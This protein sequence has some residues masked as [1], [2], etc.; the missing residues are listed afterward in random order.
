MCSKNIKIILSKI[1]GTFLK[2]H[3]VWQKFQIFPSYSITFLNLL[4]FYCNFYNVR[5]LYN[6]CYRC[7]IPSFPGILFTDSRGTGRPRHARS[8]ALR[9]RHRFVL[10]HLAVPC[11]TVWVNDN[12]VCFVL[13]QYFFWHFKYIVL[14]SIMAFMENECVI[15]YELIKF[16]SN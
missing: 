15:T 11:M 5:K 2:N 3:S 10:L 14:H 1:I 13:F 9:Q 6:A 8:V 7:E 16:L 12:F 4:W